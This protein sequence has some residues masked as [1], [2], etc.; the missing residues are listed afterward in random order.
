MN[1]ETKTDAR[2][3]AKTNEWR[4]KYLDNVN[5]LEAETQRFKDLEAVLKRLTGRLCIATLGLSPRLDVEVKRLQSLIKKESTRDELEQ[6]MSPLTDAIHSLD[7]KSS[8]PVEVATPGAPPAT[9][10]TR[11]EPAIQPFDDNAI[12][13]TMSALLSELRRDPTLTQQATALDNQLATSLPVDALT[14]VMTKLADMVGKRIQRIERAKLEAEGLL[15]QMVTRL[16][17]ITRFVA[18]HN[19]NQQQALASSES[20][21]VQLSGE[22]KAM[23]DSVATASDLMQIRT[24]VRNRLD[25]IGRHLQEYRQRETERADAMRT[26]NDQMQARVVQLEAQA[27]KLQTQLQEEQ[28]VAMMDA[29]TKVPNRLAYDKRIAEELQRFSRFGQPTCLAAWDV[30]HFKKINDTWGHAAGD[31]VLQ[32]VAEIL[33]KRARA[34]DFFGRYGGEEFVMILPGTT[35]NDAMKI[36][37]ELRIAIGNLGLHFKGTPVPLTASCGVTQFMPNDSA[38]SA[39][40]RAD[41]ALYRAKKEGRNRC[42]SS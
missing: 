9:T 27:Q 22:M 39:F 1:V 33:K 2:T 28:Q 3:D 32:S 37:D 19:Q 4:D 7:E 40:E 10:Q 16:D 42:V 15:A 6:L 11:V 18:D 12:R 14:E 34:T 20:L 21:S 31:R 8:A 38:D 23:G 35:M 29:L 24:Q 36:V 41:K 25:N 17:E 5:K 13:A 30:D 26:K